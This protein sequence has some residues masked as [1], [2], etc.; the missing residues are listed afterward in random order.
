MTDPHPL[1]KAPVLR[2]KVTRQLIDESCV[3]HS[4]DCMISRALREA[5]PQFIHVQTDMQSI[6]VTD[7]ENRCR[8]IYMT[9][10]VGQQC[11]LY[12][13]AGEKPEPFPVLL[14]GGQTV[15]MRARHAV[16]Q[17]EL[18]ARRTNIVKAHAAL[19][20]RAYEKKQMILGS[21][22]ASDVTKGTRAVH[23][24]G[25]SPPRISVLSSK[26]RFFGSRKLTR[27]ILEELADRMTV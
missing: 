15:R 24:L 14:R 9:P 7:P 22:M 16:T 4:P 10:Q 2:F 25:G 23:I 12:F 19:K 1:P 8:Y 21:T 13:D 27:K 26:D 18:A 3:A 6:R 20:K 17:E 11:L 5:H